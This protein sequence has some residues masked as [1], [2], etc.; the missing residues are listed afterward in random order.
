[1]YFKSILPFVSITKAYTCDD[2]T[3]CVIPGGFCMVF[4]EM[5]K[6]HQ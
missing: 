4:M 5:A 1:M 3:E 2:N 6:M